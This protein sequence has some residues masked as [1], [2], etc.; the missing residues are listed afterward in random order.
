MSQKTQK[1]CGSLKFTENRI[2]AALSYVWI[3]CLIPLL[4]NRQDPYVGWHAKQGLILFIAETLGMLVY[5]FPLFGQL[6]LLAFIVV[7]VVGI[8][9]ALKGE[10]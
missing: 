3:G 4:L 5:W 1:F 7:S 6:L 2:L 9:Q 8:L 10:K